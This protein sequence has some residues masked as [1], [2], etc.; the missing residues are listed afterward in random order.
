M[1]LTLV[2]A[3]TLLTTT[4]GEPRS[5]GEL[6][7]RTSDELARHAQRREAEPIAATARLVD[8]FVILRSDPR[9][10]TSPLLRSTA[11]R[12]RRRLLDTRSKLKGLSRSTPSVSAVDA[13]IG[14][15]A[16]DDPVGFGGG[17]GGDEA[18]RLLELIRRVV[19][20]DFW[21]P[22]GGPGVVV[23]DAARRALVVRATSDVHEDLKDLLRALR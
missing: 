15:A 14:N 3:A 5:I 20:P 4:T 1:I 22:T 13:V 18:G 9:H 19:R 17:V 11:V 10:D 21:Q 16:S 6:R 8:W 12:V 7:R 2:V 23:Y